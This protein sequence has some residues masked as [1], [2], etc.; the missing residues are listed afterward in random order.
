MN[1]DILLP[2]AIAEIFLGVNPLFNNVESKCFENMI[3]NV[4]HAY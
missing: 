2:K 1:V 3:K 4:R